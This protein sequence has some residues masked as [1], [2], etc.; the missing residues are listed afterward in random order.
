ME[1]HSDRRDICNMERQDNK[2]T[3]N[4]R[5]Q[6]TMEESEVIAAMVSSLHSHRNNRYHWPL[7]KDY[8]KILRQKINLNK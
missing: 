7:P 6:E 1:Y 3:E 5:I 8:K 4:H 2:Q